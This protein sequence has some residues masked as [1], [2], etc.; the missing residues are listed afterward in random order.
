MKHGMVCIKIMRKD[1][2]HT[3]ASWGKTRNINYLQEVASDL[4]SYSEAVVHG[5]EK[6]FISYSDYFQS[7]LNR[8]NGKTVQY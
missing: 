8:N 5:S 2:S 4:L 7:T 1:S 6:F 3:I